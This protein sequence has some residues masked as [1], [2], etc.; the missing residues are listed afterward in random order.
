MLIFFKSVYTGIL[1]SW[2]TFWEEYTT[3]DYYNSLNPKLELG[4]N[5]QAANKE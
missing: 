1:N 4:Y 5:N 3:D 2:D